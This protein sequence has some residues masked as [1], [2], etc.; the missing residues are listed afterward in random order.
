MPLSRSFARGYDAASKESIDY[1][2]VH[3]RKLNIGYDAGMPEHP[4]VDRE[5]INFLIDQALEFGRQK[6]KYMEE[7]ILFNINAI[8][9]TVKE[10]AKRH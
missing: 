8:R 1:L 6:N 3:P 10:K 5:V 4:S 7:G 9:S 2:Y